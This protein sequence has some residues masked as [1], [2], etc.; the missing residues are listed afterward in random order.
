MSPWLIILGWLPMLT[1]TPL[2]VLIVHK[3]VEGCVGGAQRGQETPAEV[4]RP[5]HVA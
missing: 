4:G 5:R 2:N 1:R 3:G